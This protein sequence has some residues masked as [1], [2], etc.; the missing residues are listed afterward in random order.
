MKIKEYYKKYNELKKD[1]KKKSLL[2]LGFYIIFFII[3]IALIRMNN[4]TSHGNEYEDYKNGSNSSFSIKNTLNNN[5]SFNY[6]VNLDN[7]NHIYSGTCSSNGY[8]LFDSNN[9]KYFKLNDEDFFKFDVL[10]TKCDNPMLFYDFFNYKEVS[11][12]LSDA[13]VDSTTSFG[14]GNYEYKLLISTNNLNKII[15][16]KDTD[17]DETP[18][19]IIL[20]ADSSREVNK[21]KYNLDNYCKLNNLCKNNLSVE[22]DY[23]NFGGIKDIENP[24]K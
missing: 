1:P 3:L 13:Y 14:D 24:V 9:I 12:I 19:N 4:N 16:N 23:D 17:Y 8:C 2:F 15:F 22:I 6:I 20:E 18:N 21:I 5:Y 11:Y 7:T 10:W